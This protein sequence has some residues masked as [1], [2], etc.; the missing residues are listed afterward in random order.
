MTLVKISEKG[1][2][3][4]PATL[5][6]KWNL[7]GKDTVIL[8]EDAQGIHIRPLVRL[9]DLSGIDEGKGLLKKLQEM[10]DEEGSL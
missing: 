3:V 7:E 6:K 5:R 10:R 8:T 2:I 4:I 9:S 1:Q